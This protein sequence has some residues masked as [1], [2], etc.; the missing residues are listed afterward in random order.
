MKLIVQYGESTNA[1]SVAPAAIGLAMLLLILSSTATPAL[2][3][4]TS[5]Q[6]EKPQ[7]TESSA[8]PVQE[9][10]EQPRSLDELLGLEPEDRDPT[11]EAAARRRHLEALR[12]ELDE[13]SVARSFD[14]AVEHMKLTADLLDQRFDA[15]LGTQRI[16]EEILLAFD[17][18]LQK[19]RDGQCSG[20]GSCSGGAKKPEDAGE[21]GKQPGT[22]GTQPNQG[23]PG[24]PRKPQPGMSLPDEEEAGELDETG[25][26]WGNLPQR[27][28]QMLLQGRQERFSVLYEQLTREYYRRL[29]EED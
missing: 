10:D 3:Q 28:R 12:R 22:A 16:Q 9:A 19:A 8:E 24:S 4:T 23:N 5:P 20:G 2:G 18:L 13:S 6:S 15:G 29:A 11:A 1:R 17:V 26:E 14:L 21:Q 27:V 25:A 7:A